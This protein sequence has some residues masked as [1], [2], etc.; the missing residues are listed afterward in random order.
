[1]AIRYSLKNSKASALKRLKFLPRFGVVVDFAGKELTFLNAPILETLVN[2]VGNKF[3][4]TNFI[5]VAMIQ[6]SEI[7]I[8][9]FSPEVFSF[10]P[11]DMT[12]STDVRAEA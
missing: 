11:E 10:S 2:L 6:L 7:K 4:L 8:D 9:T 5:N 1:M 3:S 12:N